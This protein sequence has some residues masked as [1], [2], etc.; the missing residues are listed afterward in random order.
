MALY[1]G[2]GMILRFCRL[3]F[4]WRI[5]KSE[6]YHDFRFLMNAKVSAEKIAM[7]AN[8]IKALGISGIISG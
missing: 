5:K 3:E 2:G 7:N 6:V 8:V 4:G 1:C